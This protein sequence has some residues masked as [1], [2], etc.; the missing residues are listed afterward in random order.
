VAR[1]LPPKRQGGSGL[2]STTIGAVELDGHE[3]R[4]LEPGVR[5]VR[6]LHPCP[7]DSGR[8]LRPLRLVDG[9]QPVNVSLHEAD[10]RLRLRLVGQTFREALDSGSLSPPHALYAKNSLIAAEQFVNQ[11]DEY[12]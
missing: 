8:A 1:A 5:A 4:A 2:N 7:G 11:A 10:L 6:P 3:R 12:I 9:R